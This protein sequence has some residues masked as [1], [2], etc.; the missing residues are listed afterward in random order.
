MKKGYSWRDPEVKNYTISIKS[1]DLPDHIKDADESILN[2]V[3]ECKT[4]SDALRGRSP[5]PWASGCTT[6]FKIIHQELEFYRR[7]NIPLPRFCP[8]CRHRERISQR[9]P[10][11]L[12]RRSCQCAGAQSDNK[13]YQNQTAHF[14]AANHCPNEFETSYA[15]ERPEIVYCEQCYQNEVA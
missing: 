11:K 10:M 8:N 7:Q 5:D 9:N 6:A 15:P 14:H 4:S 12:W 1:E 2:E 3:I 13:I